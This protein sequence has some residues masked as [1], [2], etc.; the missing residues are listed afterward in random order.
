MA[1]LKSE[2]IINITV[3]V[4]R[5]EACGVEEEKVTDKDDTC[6]RRAKI[7]PST[8]IPKTTRTATASKHRMLRTLKTI[9]CR[10]STHTVSEVS[11][12]QALESRA[13]HPHVSEWYILY[14]WLVAS[15]TSVEG[16][17]LWKLQKME[18]CNKWWW[19][20]SNHQCP[21]N[22]HSVCISQVAHLTTWSNQLLQVFLF[23]VFL[24][25]RLSLLLLLLATFQF[26][27]PLWATKEK[28][29][30]FLLVQIS[31]YQGMCVAPL[32]ETQNDHTANNK[33]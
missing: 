3:S 21:C 23:N 1:D 24:L 20:Q 10:T 31:F 12:A 4:E 11:K 8:V 28:E 19:Y 15:H 22:I 2:A 6:K 25:F 16:S 29:M 13:R 14:G 27:F 26:F 9:L 18:N 32:L 33:P 7:V 5:D 17:D 30:K